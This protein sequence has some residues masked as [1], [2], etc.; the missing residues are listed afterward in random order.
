M[1]KQTLMSGP[2]LGLS[3]SPIDISDYQSMRQYR[4]IW[5]GNVWTVGNG[6]SRTTSA[7]RLDKI[8]KLWSKFRCC[9]RSDKFL[10]YYPYHIFISWNSNYRSAPSRRYLE[11]YRLRA[12][13]PFVFVD[14][15]WVIEAPGVVLIVFF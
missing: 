4:Q 13:N 6:I 10:R 11:V 8:N 7:L 15:V 9:S 1:I 14:H 5:I 2:C 3:I 12:E